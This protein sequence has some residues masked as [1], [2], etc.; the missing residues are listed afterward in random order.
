M[1]YNTY[2]N[3][4]YKYIKMEVEQQIEIISNDL[5]KKYGIEVS[6]KYKSIAYEIYND[7]KYREKMKILID[8][9]YMTLK[10]D[11]NRYVDLH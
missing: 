7:E 10:N 1:I 4:I 8:I 9:Q 11:K 5:E 2:K 6:N 3:I